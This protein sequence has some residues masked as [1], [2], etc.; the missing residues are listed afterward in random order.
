MVKKE[1]KKAGGRKRQTRVQIV[2]KAP[3]KNYRPLRRNFG[4]IFAAKISSSKIFTD[5]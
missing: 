5:N 3:T 4:C 2:F 1:E